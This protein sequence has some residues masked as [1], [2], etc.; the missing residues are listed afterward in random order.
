MF[1]ANGNY[2]DSELREEL[3]RI[4]FEV[5]E[6]CSEVIHY[7]YEGINGPNTSN[8]FKIRNY[9]HFPINSK[10]YHEG[11]MYRFVYEEYK[12]PYL[13]K[14][15]DKLLRGN[16]SV[17]EELENV[18]LSKELVPFEE[19]IELLSRELDSI[20]NRNIREKR[21]KLNELEYYLVQSEYNKRQVS[22]IPYY[23]IVLEL[24]R[25]YNKL[26]VLNKGNI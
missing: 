13:V 9:I 19:K 25:K 1:C 6:R 17:I 8:P 7:D 21:E 20:P 22:V 10:S 2:L 15:I 23:Q 4:R 24:V 5:I 11:K 16:Y 3:M 12:F 18:D 26:L 14:I